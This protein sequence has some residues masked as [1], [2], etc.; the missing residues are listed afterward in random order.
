MPTALAGPVAAGAGSSRRDRSGR[1]RAAIR[2]YLDE[3]DGAHSGVTI[4]WGVHD[5]RG[6]RGRHDR[7]LW[8]RSASREAAGRSAGLYRL[9]PGDQAK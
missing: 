7:R 8:R 1:R 6:S 2:G 3:A 9:T 5:A 4:H